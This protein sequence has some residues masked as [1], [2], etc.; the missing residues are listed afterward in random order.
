MALH[1]NGHVNNQ[2]KSGTWRISSVIC[3]VALW[4]H[5]SAAYQECPTTVDEVDLGHLQSKDCWNL[6]LH[7]H[8]DVET[9]KL[10]RNAARPAPLPP[11]PGPHHSRHD[12][13]TAPPTCPF[14][15]VGRCSV[16]APLPTSDSR[17]GQL[18]RLQSPPQRPRPSEKTVSLTRQ[19]WYTSRAPDGCML[20]ASSLCT[21]LWLYASFFSPFSFSSKSFPSE[22]CG[23]GCGRGRGRGRGCGGCGSDTRLDACVC[24][25]TPPDTSGQVSGDCATRSRPVEGQPSPG[26]GCRA[27]KTALRNDCARVGAESNSNDTVVDLRSAI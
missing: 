11:T 14:F 21:W 13:A 10:Q 20:T 23:C 26:A 6:S 12:P 2:S 4:V 15:T 24:P 8:R 17:G 7:D 18:P 19:P 16:R 3:T 25:D 27:P 5:V 1:T 9:E 22:G